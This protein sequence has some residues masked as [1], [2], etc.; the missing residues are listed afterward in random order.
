MT[1]PQSHVHRDMLD[2]VF[3]NRNRAY[4][5]YALR[6]SYPKY[7]RNALLLGVLLIGAAF[8]VPTLLSAVATRLQPVA[9]DATVIL[10][11]PPDVDPNNTPPPP[12]PPPTPPPPTRTTITF[13]PPVIL[14]NDEVKEEQQHTIEELQETPADIGKV[15]VKGNDDAPPAIVENPSE[16]KAVEEVKAP[17][18]PEKT[19]ELFDIH[20]APGFPGGERELMKYLAENIKYPALARENN[21]QGKVTL[22]FVVNKDGSISDVS[23][24]RD[25]GGGCGKEAVRVVGNMPRWLPG[26]ANGNPVKV[27]FTLPVQFKLE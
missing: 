27:R 12:P 18:P 1:N 25:V 2:I 22:T 7:L 26:E 5:A 17:P 13:V 10:E 23:V 19:Y 15:D 8:A 11:P 21:I 9:F 20:K 24:L 16:L 14:P 3:A 4:G 6:R